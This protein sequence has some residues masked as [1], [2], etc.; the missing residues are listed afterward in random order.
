MR[1]F[2]T[3]LVIILLIAFLFLAYM[4]M[5]S[6]ITISERKMGPYTYAYVNHVGPYSEV[7]TLIMDQYIKL[8]EAG[9]NSVDAI[10]IYY[11]DPQ[12]TPKEQ[13][14]S[15]AGLIIS[16]QDMG[17]IEANKGKFNF[18]TIEEKTYFVTEFP[19]KNNLSYII[20]PMKIYPAFG[21]FTKDNNITAPS[22]AIEYYDKANS[23]II[24]MMEKN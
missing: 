20:G 24:F 12:N 4:G 10:G 13:L 21:K 9:F 6:N 23:K 19:I 11:D 1:I 7:G 18:G 15:D 22:K 2:L 8:E 5:F 16:K 3:I 17:K 14:K